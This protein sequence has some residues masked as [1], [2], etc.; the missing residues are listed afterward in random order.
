MEK[1]EN[2]GKI[3]EDYLVKLT[4]ETIKTHK[5]NFPQYWYPKK[6]TKSSRDDYDCHKYTDTD[7][8]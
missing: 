5:K 6:I 1:S 3:K 7:D 4:I 2:N 8:Y